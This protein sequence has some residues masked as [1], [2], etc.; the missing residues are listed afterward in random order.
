MRMNDITRCRSM[1][2]TAFTTAIPSSADDHRTSAP[3]S[4]ARS[5][6]S[7]AREMTSGGNVSSTIH[8][9][10]TRTPTATRPRWD[11]TSHHRK[12]AGPR[13]SGVPGSS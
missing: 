4:P 8:V 3:V 6:S 10:L 9:V 7:M 12:R 13:A 2:R 5:P 1:P 11:T